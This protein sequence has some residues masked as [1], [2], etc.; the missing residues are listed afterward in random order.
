MTI[1]L[2]HFAVS[3]TAFVWLRPLLRRFD[4]HY[5]LHP[6]KDSDFLFFCL[7]W[8]VILFLMLLYV[9]WR[10]TLWHFVHRLYKKS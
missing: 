10:N 9:V 2:I 3:L 6:S 7:T 4:A 8:S 5:E 1:F